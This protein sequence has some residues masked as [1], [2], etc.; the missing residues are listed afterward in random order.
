MLATGLHI[1]YLRELPGFSQALQVV[2]SVLQ[3]R[4]LVCKSMAEGVRLGFELRSNHTTPKT[5]TT[6]IRGDG[7]RIWYRND[8]ERVVLE[9]PQ[10]FFELQSGSRQFMCRK[11]PPPKD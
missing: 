5:N 2:P 11:D 7:A 6:D 9:H 4:L 1:E 10:L 3:V 8:M